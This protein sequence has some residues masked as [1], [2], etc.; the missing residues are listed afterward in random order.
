M[1]AS[2]WLISEAHARWQVI[3]GK[4]RPSHPRITLILTGAARREEEE[5]AD[6]MKASLPLPSQT[7]L[8]CSSAQTLPFSLGHAINKVGQG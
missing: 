4:E 7:A 2:D 5:E 6:M 3:K 1:A 8:S